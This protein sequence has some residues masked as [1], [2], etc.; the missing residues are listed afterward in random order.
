MK[1][2]GT[3]KERTTKEIRNKIRK[4]EEK[5]KSTY[6]F[7][8]SEIGSGMSETDG[9]QSFNELLTK[10]FKCYFDLEPTHGYSA[11]AKPILT[12]DDVELFDEKT[13]DSEIDT[14]ANS[15]VDCNSD[16]SGFSESNINSSS[17]KAARQ[18]NYED[19]SFAEKEDVICYVNA[20]EDCPMESFKKIL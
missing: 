13:S 5:F 6:D 10:K 20:E 2:H 19:V 4:Y 11:C 18:P 8:T 16:N 1:I 14:N 9:V 7:A 12:A 3:T 15:D 17:N